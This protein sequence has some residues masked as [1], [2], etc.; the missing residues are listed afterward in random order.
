MKQ[1]LENKLREL[2]Y[3]LSITS[4]DH[5]VSY[6]QDQRKVTIELLRSVNNT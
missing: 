3:I 4:N 6:Y 1:W 2:N 5:V